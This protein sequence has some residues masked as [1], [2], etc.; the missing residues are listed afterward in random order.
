MRDRP[1]ENRWIGQRIDDPTVSIER[2]AASLGVESTG[3]IETVKDL[4]PALEHALS[5]VESGKPYLINVHVDKGY[6]V[7][8]PARE[9]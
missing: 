8:P 7:P 2:Y 3:P 4:V 6:A 5:V 9:A 1:V